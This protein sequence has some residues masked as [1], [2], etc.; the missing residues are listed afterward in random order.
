MNDFKSFLKSIF[1]I[2]T[3]KTNFNS[4]LIPHLKMSMKSVCIEDPYLSEKYWTNRY[5]TEYRT[6]PLY[7]RSWRDWNHPSYGY[8]YI[9]PRESD[10]TLRFNRHV[11]P[12]VY[13]PQ[14]Q[15]QQQN[16]V[17]TQ[18]PVLKPGTERVEQIKIQRMPL[19]RSNSFVSLI[20]TKSEVCDDD[21]KYDCNYDYNYLEELGD[22]KSIRKTHKSSISNMS[23]SMS[24][25]SKSCTFANEPT[26]IE[27]VSKHK[28]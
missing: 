2:I 7:G 1:Q 28:I 13:Y 25:M 17:E 27:P 18:Q 23:K 16:V 20:E 14:Q 26:I 6:S 15:Q 12:S 8:R 22:C 4:D 9:S 10:D 19:K 3:L 5:F 24:N 11:H 21:G